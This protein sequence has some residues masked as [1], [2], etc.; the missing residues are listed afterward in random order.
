MIQKEKEKKKIQFAKIEM[1]P[2]LLGIGRSLVVSLLFLLALLFG[3]R[4]SQSL[5]NAKSVTEHITN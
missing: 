1:K 3:K 4:L 5:Y 2:S